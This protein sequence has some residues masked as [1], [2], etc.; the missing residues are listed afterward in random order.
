VCRDCGGKKRY[1]DQYG[2]THPGC[3]LCS[4]SGVVKLQFIETTIDAACL[5]WFSP[6]GYRHS[7][8]HFGAWREWPEQPAPNDWTPN[9]KGKDLT[10]DQTAESLM[11][12]ERYFPDRPKLR[13]IEWDYDYA[14]VDDFSTY[15]LHVGRTD[16]ECCVLC[17]RRSDLIYGGHGCRAGRITWSAVVCN[18]CRALYSEGVEIFRRCEA[19]LPMDLITPHVAQ[20]IK[21]HPVPPI[22]DK[23]DQPL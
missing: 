4:S 20:W 2:F 13:H 23:H 12:I 6:T 19:R 18:A 21:T 1:T 15:S 9:Q 14:S 17:E 8:S 16:P 22:R 7:T 3:R 5:V 10:V 11:V